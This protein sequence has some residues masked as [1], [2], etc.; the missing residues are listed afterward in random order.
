MRLRPWTFSQVGPAPARS[1]PAVSC[2]SSELGRALRPRFLTQL[3]DRLL[4]L[5]GARRGKGDL[6]ADRAEAGFLKDS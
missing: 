5:G 6:R 1:V 2:P 3:E 4:Y